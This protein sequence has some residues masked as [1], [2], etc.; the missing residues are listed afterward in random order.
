MPRGVK[1]STGD[2]RLALGREIG[3]KLSGLSAGDRA[4]VLEIAGEVVAA[5][6]KA[7]TQPVKKTHKKKAETPAA[8]EPAAAPVKKAA[9]KKAGKKAAAPEPPAPARPS[10]G[11]TGLFG[12]GRKGAAPGSE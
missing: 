2:S 1:K 11:V 5:A 8:K 10:A 12:R 4:L 7:A 3:K 9:G 6:T